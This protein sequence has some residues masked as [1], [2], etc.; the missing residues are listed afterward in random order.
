MKNYWN[1]TGTYEALGKKLNAMIPTGGSVK[2]PEKNPK[3]ERYRKMVNA[4]YDLYCNGGGNS[5]R[6]TAYYF[7]KT[8]TLARRNNWDECYKITEPI[9]DKAILLASKEQGVRDG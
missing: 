4:Y 7:P 5:C 3:L 6:K 8:I 9:M 2:N 1:E